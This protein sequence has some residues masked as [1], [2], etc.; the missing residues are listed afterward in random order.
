MLIGHYWYYLGVEFESLMGLYSGSSKFCVLAGQVPV[1]SRT[2]AKF[3]SPQR[4][5]RYMA[6]V[7]FL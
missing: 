5:V 3:I 6:C 4:L 2:H 1:R 7:G